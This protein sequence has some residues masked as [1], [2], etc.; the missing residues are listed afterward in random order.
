[1][2]W[3]EVPLDHFSEYHI[4]TPLYRG[5]TYSTQHHDIPVPT[6]GFRLGNGDG[7]EQQASLIQSAIFADHKELRQVNDNVSRMG[8]RHGQRYTEGVQELLAE[9]IALDSEVISAGEPGLQGAAA[10]FIGRQA[11][12]N[13]K[14][15][16]S[17]FPAVPIDFERAAAVD[18]GRLRAP[19]PTLVGGINNYDHRVR[20][21]VV[22]GLSEAEQRRRAGDE[23]RQRERERKGKFV[24][25]NIDLPG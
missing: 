5:R 14:Y 9:S 3:P 20:S 7:A 4:L 22:D 6:A 25:R 16:K 17:D 11:L 1:L 21:G 19:A 2:Q 15:S 10:T 24:N 12:K 13:A 23:R 18:Y 8:R